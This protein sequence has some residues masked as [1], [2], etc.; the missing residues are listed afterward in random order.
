MGKGKGDIKE[1]IA[2]ISKGRILFEFIL[3]VK[4]F[5]LRKV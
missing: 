3:R 5:F 2:K 1:L 4:R